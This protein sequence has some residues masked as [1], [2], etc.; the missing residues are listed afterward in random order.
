MGK[1]GRSFGERI[2]SLFHRKPYDGEEGEPGAGRNA[3]DNRSGLRSFSFSYDGTIGGN[4]Y[5]YD[6]KEKDGVW[7]LS[8]ESMEHNDYG[9]LTAET[10]S[11]VA[12]KLNDL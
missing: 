2:G 7:T 9:K 6:L 12:D 3:K 5:S 4:N 10:E 11:A 1:N 8:Y